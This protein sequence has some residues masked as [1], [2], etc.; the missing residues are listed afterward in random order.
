MGSPL[1]PLAFSLFFL[2]E[3]I[4]EHGSGP[5]AP[6]FSMF[7]FLGGWVSLLSRNKQGDPLAFLLFSPGPLGF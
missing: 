7:F 3:G 2:W 5:L 1:A 6:L 4:F